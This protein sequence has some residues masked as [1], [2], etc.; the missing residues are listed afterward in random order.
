MDSFG[1]YGDGDGQFNRPIDIAQDRAGNLYVSD[2]RNNRV[3][4]FDCKGQFL[5]TFRK[6]DDCLILK[7]F[8][9]NITGRTAEIADRLMTQNNDDQR[10]SNKVLEFS[11]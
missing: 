8:S 1:C 9:T 6:K 3:Q 5:S 2:S 7:L 4:A 10:V 11:S